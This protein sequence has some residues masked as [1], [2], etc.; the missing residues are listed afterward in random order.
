MPGVIR[1]SFMGL[2]AYVLFNHQDSMISQAQTSQAQKRSVLLIFLAFLLP[3]LVGLLS[4]QI[5]G[6]DPEK[7]LACAIFVTA[8]WLWV[9]ELLPVA[10]TALLVPALQVFYQVSDVET[11]FRP[12]ASSIIFL[13]IGAF[14]LGVSF[15]KHGLA[16][17]IACWLLSHERITSS[18]ARLVFS[19]ALLSFVFSMWVSNTVTVAMLTP[20]AISIAAIVCNSF[21]GTDEQERFPIL[22]LLALA[23]SSTVGGMATPVGSPPNLITL[24]FLRRAGVDISFGHWMSFGLPIAAILFVLVFIY[25]NRVYRVTNFSARN[26]RSIHEEFAEKLYELGPFSRAETQVFLCFVCTVSLWILPDLAALLVDDSL[27]ATIRARIPLSVVA[28]F[29]AAS[30]FALPIGAGKRNLEASDFKEVDWSTVLLFGG[31]LSLGAMLETSG[32]AG[33]LCSLVFSRVGANLW[34]V[35]LIAG[36]LTLLFTE[37]SSNT[38]SA[39]IFLSILVAML[40]ESI[41]I[42]QAE[43]LFMIGLAGSC[44]FMMPIATPPN[45][46]VYASG[47]IPLRSMI[48]IG[49]VLNVISFVVISVMIL[50]FRA[51]LW[52]VY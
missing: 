41:G 17:R 47:H 9:F 13:F 25:L 44:G 39:S 40:G 23:Y 12:F 27:V 3:L 52:F 8:I 11:V 20:L 42:A 1:L 28:V 5:S 43:P 22:L 50:L 35:A 37:V 32:V 6:S 19:F 49:I 10:V 24:E 16:R 2:L 4:V 33:E 31:G 46:I 48:A 14:L 15:H 34:L 18:P 51:H 45:A 21:D 38:A 7:A 26:N 36:G 29:G 30:L